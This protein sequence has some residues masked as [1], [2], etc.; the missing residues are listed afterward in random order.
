MSS[1]AMPSQVCKGP[2]VSERAFGYLRW[3]FGRRYTR[4]SASE[5]GLEG[6]FADGTFFQFI[7]IV[8]VLGTPLDR[9]CGG[10]SGGEAVRKPFRLAVWSVARCWLVG[11]RGRT[12]RVVLRAGQRAVARE[13][14]LIRLRVTDPAAAGGL[15]MLWSLGRLDCSLDR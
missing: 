7:G 1:T 8:A 12:G 13:A 10:G 4:R 6:S 3:V 2:F 11:V 5:D 9:W 15:R 14:L